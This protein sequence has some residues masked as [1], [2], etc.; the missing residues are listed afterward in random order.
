MALIEFVGSE[1][2]K[3]VEDKDEKPKSKGKTEAKGKA[4]ATKS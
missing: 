3:P 4:E 1:T 2:K